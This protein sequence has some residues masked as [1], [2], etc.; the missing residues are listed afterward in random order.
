MTDENTDRC[1]QKQ[2]TTYRCLSGRVARNL[3]DDEGK[4]VVTAEGEK[5][6]IVKSVDRGTA[7]VDPDPG[8][9][10]EMKSKMGGETA[11]KTPTNS[12]R[13]ASTR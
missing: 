7:H 3:T 8:M 4:D 1:G 6:G 13:T 11:T 12:T 9:T 10:D 5:V 2:L